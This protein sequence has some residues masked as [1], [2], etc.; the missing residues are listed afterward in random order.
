MNI[1]WFD[2]HYRVQVVSSSISLAP[3][4]SPSPLLDI[5]ASVRTR[6]SQASSLYGTRTGQV[7]ARTRMK[8]RTWDKWMHDYGLP[9]AVQVQ[10]RR[11]AEGD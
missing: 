11:P 3:S 1:N 2:F 5:R 6:K 10:T 9:G 4:G 8:T 7:G